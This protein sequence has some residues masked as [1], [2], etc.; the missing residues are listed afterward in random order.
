VAGH[1]TIAGRLTPGNSPGTLT[2]EQGL[3]L[4]AT[5]E[6]VMEILGVSVGQ[7]DVVRIT[8]GDFN[9]GGTLVFDLALLPEGEYTIPLFE[10]GP[11]VEVSGEFVQV[12]LS[13]D[14]GEHLFTYD[15]IDSTWRLAIGFN[16]FAFQ[17]LTGELDILL[18]PEP[19]TGVALLGVGALLLLRRRRSG[20]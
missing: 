14:Y 17:T 1:A 11:G 19:S 18:I 15:E 9:A 5:S 2:F 4:G 8:G 13:G 7:Y 3:T 20:T 16:M 12:L 6:T 10:I